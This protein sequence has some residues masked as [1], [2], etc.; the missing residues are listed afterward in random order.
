MGVKSGVLMDKAIRVIANANTE[1][2]NDITCSIFILGV[3][4]FVA[5][6]NTPNMAKKI[7]L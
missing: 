4:A 1:S 3:N 7:L 2:L 5:M 6:G